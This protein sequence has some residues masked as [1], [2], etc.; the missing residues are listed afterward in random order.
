MGKCT[1]TW[2]S[3]LIHGYVYSYMGMCTHTWVCVLKHGYVYPYVC[4]GMLITLNSVYPLGNCHVF[5]NLI[6]AQFK[7]GQNVQWCDSVVKA[8]AS[9]TR[10]PWFESIHLRNYLM[11]MFTVN[12]RKD[13]YKE[14]R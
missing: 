2:V 12:C 10:G 9:R 7:L 11:N 13:L 14:K 5:Y 3:V 8:V 4:M 1:D 6:N